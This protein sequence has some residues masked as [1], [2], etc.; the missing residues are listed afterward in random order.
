MIAKHMDGMMDVIDIKKGVQI[1][2]SIDKTTVWVNVDGVCVC[3]L[4]RIYVPIEIQIGSVKIIRDQQ[5]EIVG[6]DNGT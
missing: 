1:I 4:N 5:V 3:R 2:S 6:R